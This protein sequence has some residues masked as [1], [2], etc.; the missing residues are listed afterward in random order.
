[1]LLGRL[2]VTASCLAAAACYSPPEPD[3]GF[4]C[5]PNNTCPADYACAAD[6]HCHRN[7][8]PAS[9]VCGTLPDAA[10][11]TPA[12]PRVLATEPANNTTGVAVNVV[13]TAVIDQAIVQF[14]PLDVD[15]TDAGGAH[16][17]GHGD[18]PTGTMAVRYLP[19]YQLAANTKFTV[20]ISSAVL[21]T[22]GPVGPYAWSFTTGGDN[23]APHAVFVD[24]APGATMVGTGTVISVDFDEVVTGVDTT[25]FTVTDGVTPVVGTITTTGGH[26]YVFTPAAP[27]AALTAYT[28]DLSAAIH[29]STGNALV[30]Y[31][32]M[33]TTSA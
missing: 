28:V 13:P 29:D 27:L 6:R 8:A 16:V 33:F 3:C 20:T 9:L 32:Y 5:G 18:A 10:V 22:S 24:P 11:D 17:E 25:S 26:S 31:S 23:I 1:M 14:D 21:A 2:V 12:A 15:M 19:S 30:D 4:A 7:G